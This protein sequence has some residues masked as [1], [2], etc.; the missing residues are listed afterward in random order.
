[1][2]LIALI[3][4]RILLAI[5]FIASGVNKLQQLE[6]TG[7]M[8]ASAGLPAQLAMPVGAFELVAGAALAVGVLP[9]LTPLL[10]AAFTLLTILYFHANIADP[11]QAVQAMKNVAIIGGLLAVLAAVQERRSIRVVH[12]APVRDTRLEA[13]EERAHAAELR[14]ARAEGT[15]DP[16]VAR[17]AYVEDR[18][19]AGEPRREPLDR[20]AGTFADPAGHIPLRQP[21]YRRWF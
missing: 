6:S 1:M 14:A 17:S 10:L 8:I 15:A 5:L 11:M 21:W 3:I 20:P 9:R 7:A 2:A 12:S 18:D 16:V 13:A 19:Y 4:G